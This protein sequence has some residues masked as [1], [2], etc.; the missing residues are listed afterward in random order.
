MDF[1]FLAEA[2]FV[3]ILPL[4]LLLG[5]GKLELAIFEEQ[6]VSLEILIEG[7]SPLIQHLLLVEF[8]LLLQL[9]FIVRPPVAIL[10]VAQQLRHVLL[11]LRVLR[12][13]SLALAKWV[14]ARHFSK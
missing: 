8:A 12:N 3:F 6:L 10:V 9:G 14:G 7:G 2:L 13:L 11:E 4:L 5:A 1:S